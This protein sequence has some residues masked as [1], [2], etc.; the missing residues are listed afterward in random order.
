MPERHEPLW[1]E[2]SEEQVERVLRD[3][4]DAG[5]TSLLLSGRPQVRDALAGAGQIAEDG[6]LSRSL[7]WGLMLLAAFPADGSYVGNAEIARTLG[8]SMSTAH[9]YI[10]TLLAVGL[11]ERHPDTR[12]Y[13]LTDAG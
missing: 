8:M 10:S 7:L 12:Q 13:R 11:L 4:S 3:A 1:I 5:S 2:L 9:R 6:R